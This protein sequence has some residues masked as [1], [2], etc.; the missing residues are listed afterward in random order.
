M[1]CS[2]TKCPH[3]NLRRKAR[4]ANGCDIFPGVG[5]LQCRG[6]RP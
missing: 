1:A 6:F 3:N 2:N 4:T 5:C